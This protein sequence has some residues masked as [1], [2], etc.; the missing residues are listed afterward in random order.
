MSRVVLILFGI[1]LLAIS[2]LGIS[3]PGNSLEW[4][5][6]AEPRFNVLRISTAILLLAYGLI[7]YLRHGTTQL[8]MR[9]VGLVFIS[10]PFAGIY[11]DIPNLTMLPLDF[12]SFTEAGIVAL[13]LSLE[14]AEGEMSK[15]TPVGRHDYSKASGK[16]TS[17][18]EPSPKLA[19][20]EHASGNV[21]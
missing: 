2:L 1:S 11:T 20:I 6:G 5:L 19:N 9:V 4:L 12:F 18:P 16:T 21:N 8:A 14:P 13:L 10:L 7:P 17:V 15:K 3:E